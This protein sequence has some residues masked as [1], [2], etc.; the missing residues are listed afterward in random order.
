VNP[1]GY[2]LHDH[3]TQYLG[4]SFYFERISEFQSV[5]FHSLTAAY[6]ESLLV[7]A[8]AAAAWHVGTGRQIQVLLLLT[9]SHL[10]LFSVRNIPIFAVVSTPG[11]GLA[12]R[13]WLRLVDSRCPLDWRGNLSAGL[14]EVEM[15]LGVIAGDRNRNRWH[16]APCVA[17][18][19]LVW[20]VSHP[21]RSRALHADFDP[22][23]FP[24]DATTFLSDNG[25][26]PSVR[27]Y[28]SWQWGGYLIYRLW[29]SVRV[30]DDGRTDFYGPPFVLEELRV[31][32][33]RPDWTEIL[34]RYGVNAALVPVDSALGTVLRERADWK[35]VY[36]DRVALMFMKIENRK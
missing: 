27:L 7:L 25:L 5:D 19:A 12:L 10:A 9:W 11:I 16:L 20:F 13:D 30:F 3:V 34:A 6:F 22:S 24:T 31:W 15:G 35:L 8:I 18:L 33:V 28:A 36:A 1:Y 21:G 26:V 23:R 4:A 29:P 14:A 17:V 32:E 2:R